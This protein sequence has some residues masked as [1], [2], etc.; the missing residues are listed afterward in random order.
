MLKPR[1]RIAQASW[2]LLNIYNFELSPILP[3]GPNER[4][5]VVNVLA[6]EAAA[7]KVYK[8][9]PTLGKLL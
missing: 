7:F 8:S 9:F 3:V 1:S 2:A 4:N 5:A 6:L